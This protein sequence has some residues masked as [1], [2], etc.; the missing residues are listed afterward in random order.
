MAWVED[1]VVSDG[2]LLFTVDD[3]AVRA[4][5][6]RTGQLVG[7]MVSLPTEVEASTFSYDGSWLAAGD[8]Y[9]TIWVWDTRSGELRF[10]LGGGHEHSGIAILAA[11]PENTLLSHESASWSMQTW[12]IQRGEIIGTRG[13]SPNWAAISPNGACILVY[14]GDSVKLYDLGSPRHGKVVGAIGRADPFQRMHAMLAFSA[15][16]QWFAIGTGGVTEVWERSAHR[17]AARLPSGGGAIALTSGGDQLATATRDHV[18]I[19]D[20]RTSEIVR[21]LTMSGRRDWADGIRALAFSPDGRVL[22]V[23]VGDRI[24]MV[25]VRSGEARGLI[26]GLG[27]VQ[28]TAT[29]PDGQYVA[30]AG[31][32]GVRVWNAQTF[33]VVAAG[34][35]SVR[36]MVFV[37]HKECLAIA[38][39]SEIAILDL[40]DSDKLIR[41]ACPGV[42]GEDGIAEMV[43]SRAGQIVVRS[44]AGRLDIVDLEDGRARSLAEA[45]PGAVDIIAISPNG[46]WLATG[47]QDVSIRRLLD[48]SIVAT[49]RTNRRVKS[50][51]WAPDSNSIVAGGDSGIYFL[52]FVNQPE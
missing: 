18:T 47:G 45:G 33:K 46:R 20:T 15:D 17:V 37:P 35:G 13:S 41:Y 12:D 16:G 26:G 28:V 39:L 25:D 1:I 34:Y 31:S 49:H 9:G 30:V 50:L 44:M 4:W 29:S 3:I 21:E 36:C 5:D 40:R 48:G 51:A 32:L 22:G 10:T 23:A 7:S 14:E 27:R 52:T 38:G 43:V 24:T 2:R 8:H 19:R 11:T 6:P 42:K